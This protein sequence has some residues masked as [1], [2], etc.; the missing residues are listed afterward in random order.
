MASRKLEELSEE[1]LTYIEKILGKEFSRQNNHNSTWK[2]KNGYE[3]TS[4]DTRKISKI[5]DAIRSEK[6]Y[7]RQISIKW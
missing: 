3:C 1:D 2:A 7:K 6:H 5:M 4:D